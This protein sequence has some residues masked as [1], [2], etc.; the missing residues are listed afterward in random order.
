MDLFLRAYPSRS[1]DPFTASSWH[2]LRARRMRLYMSTLLGFAAALA[3]IAALSDG[4][5]SAICA[6][7]CSAALAL[8][9]LCAFATARSHRRESAHLSDPVLDQSRY[10]INA[11]LAATVLIVV[12]GAVW[13]ISTWIAVAVMFAAAACCGMAL[14]WSH[15]VLSVI[16]QAL[17]RPTVPGTSAY[18]ADK[19]E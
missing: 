18:T 16:K 15:L 7:A 8:A 6:S 19:P 9:A 2:F 4:T 12:S 5:A 14:R 13:T 3:G 17:G 1:T 11:L 10:S